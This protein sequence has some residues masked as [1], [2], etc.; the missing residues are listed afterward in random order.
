MAL[1][2]MH[3][4]AT[5][6][7]TKLLRQQCAQQTSEEIE[8]LDLSLKG[9]TTIE[10]LDICTRLR[11]LVLCNNAIDAIRNVEVC[12]HLWRIDLTGNRVKS[13]EGLCRFP[14]FG[15]LELGF[16][17]LEWNALNRLSHVTILHLTL[18]GNASLETDPNYRRH[19]IDIFPQLWMLDGKLITANERQHVARFFA[20]SQF[21]SQPV[22]RRAKESTFV[23]S[24]QKNLMVNGVFGDKTVQLMLKFP[25]SY[26]HNIEM[27]KRRLLHL[28][29]AFDDDLRLR[30]MATPSSLECVHLAKLM[31]GRRHAVQQCNMVLLLLAAYHEYGLPFE[32]MQATL[33]TTKLASICD[34]NT[35][36]LFELPAQEAIQVMSLLFSAASVDRQEKQEGGLYQRLYDSLSHTLDALNRKV[37]SCRAKRDTNTKKLTVVDDRTAQLRSLLSSEV[38]HLLCLVPKFIESIETNR[39]WIQQIIITATRNSH[40]LDNIS[41]IKWKVEAGGGDS[42]QAYHDIADHLL[43]SVNENMAPLGT[44]SA[45]DSP[46]Y[47][48]GP[49]SLHRTLSAD[50]PAQRSHSASS[51]RR[52]VSAGSR[53]NKKPDVGDSVM[54][55]PETFARIVA[56]P[57]GDIAVLQTTSKSSNIAPAEPYFYASVRNLVWSSAGHWIQYDTTPTSVQ[58]S[59]SQPCVM[60]QHSPRRVGSPGPDSRPCSRLSVMSED[61]H[62]IPSG[63]SLLEEESSPT[64]LSAT[65]P[66]KVDIRHSIR[67]MMCDHL[68]A[69]QQLDEISDTHDRHTLQH[70]RVLDAVPWEGSQ[71]PEAM[72]EELPTSQ[73]PPAGGSLTIPTPR[74]QTPPLWDSTRS[75]PTSNLRAHSCHH[76]EALRYMEALDPPLAPTSPVYPALPPST[77]TTSLQPSSSRDSSLAHFCGSHA[78]PGHQHPA[79][80]QAW[81]VV[82]PTNQARNAAKLMSRREPNTQARIRQHSASSK[83]APSQDRGSSGGTTIV[84]LQQRKSS[85]HSSPVPR[86][87]TPGPPPPTRAS[88]TRKLGQIKNMVVGGTSFA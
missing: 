24:S 53:G 74:M 61:L 26:T 7:T 11:F 73:Y 43:R 60:Y 34:V 88:S 14:A 32:V 72:G 77:S 3:T 13:V 2:N 63:Q 57:Q 20:S 10:C 87:T 29:A 75:T 41:G 55:P 65:P 39:G 79:V 85:A 33:E 68:V 30:S 83:P 86:P 50:L 22:R 49:P 38:I 69:Q 81:A 46:T 37:I 19:V 67:G 40:I 62:V 35:V 44:S 58:S 54:V 70:S 28:A 64:H 78:H 52:L 5:R 47:N 71:E 9:I 51:V 4:K 8:Y 66:M 15:T 42:W 6:I 18:T 1:S 76:Q 12:R 25:V 36:T 84:I 59:M 17:E 21:S 45:G 48:H 56:L 16:N 23:P 82:R 31:E 27:D 80:Y